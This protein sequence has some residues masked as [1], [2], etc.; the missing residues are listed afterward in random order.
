MN[1][2]YS[3]LSTTRNSISC[4]GAELGHMLLLNV[5]RKVCMESSMVQLHLTFVNLKGHS[6]GRS[7]FERLYPVKSGDR[8]C[9]TIKHK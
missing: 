2:S 5:N 7:D 8:P 4:K 1:Q 9:V 6:Q 3:L